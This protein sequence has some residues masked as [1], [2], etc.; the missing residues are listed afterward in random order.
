[1]G[2]NPCRSRLADFFGSVGEV[3]LFGLRAIRDVFRRPLELTEI[4]KQTFEIG[5]RSIP[6]VAVSGF[7]FGVVIA[8]QTRAEMQSFGAQAMIPQAISTGLFTDIGPLLTALLVAGRVGAGIGAELAGMRVTE[9]IDALE[10]L[11]IDS[12]KYLVITRVVAC[13]IAVPVLTTVFNFSGLAGGMLS[14]L[15]GLH[16]TVRLFLN[17]AFNSMGWRDYVFPT[18]QTVVF[19]FIIGTLSCYLGYTASQGAAGVG[20]ASTRSVVFSSLAV[21]LAQVIL[22]KSIQFWFAG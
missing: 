20:K 18:L 13:V 5:W 22:V 6:L 3:G 10:A 4:V 16:M 9:Q 15:L 2:R 11:A 17:E 1:M 8:L 21:I 14:D 19:G 12:F 7:A